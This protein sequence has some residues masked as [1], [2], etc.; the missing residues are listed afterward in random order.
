M[1]MDPAS[2][3]QIATLNTIEIMLHS[4]HLFLHKNLQVLIS[5][6]LSVAPALDGMAETRQS[7]RLTT[8]L[9]DLSVYSGSQTVQNRDTINGLCRNL[10]RVFED[11][12]MQPTS[13]DFD[14]RE[15][16]KATSKLVID[17]VSLY[18]NIVASILGRP[19]WCIE[20]WQGRLMGTD[21]WC[22]PWLA[23]E[24]RARVSLL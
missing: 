7:E 11:V 6:V 19:I 9:K 18:A 10:G 5:F 4:E 23:M 1:K 20:N 14:E 17:Y 24:H 3:A 21:T 22:L 8:L 12:A 16:S 2:S 13:D 15:L